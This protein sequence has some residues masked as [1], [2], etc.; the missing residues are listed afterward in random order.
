MN[1][2]GTAI[3]ATAILFSMLASSGTRPGPSTRS[4]SNGAPQR[5]TSSSAKPGHPNCEASDCKTPKQAGEKDYQDSITDLFRQYCEN[6]IG[7]GD[8]DAS[9]KEAGRTGKEDED[10]TEKGVGEK[11]KV[12]CRLQPENF[13]I[14][15]VPDPV[16]THLALYFDRT[17]DTIEEA[18]Q[19]DGYNF[20]QAIVPWDQEAHPQPDDFKLRL[21]A[22]EYQ[23]GKEHFPGVMLFTPSGDL[24]G[25]T[26]VVVDAPK[27]PLAVMLVAESPTAGVNKE[28]FLNAIGQIK[29]L[30]PVT[31]TAKI[32][33]K[34]LGPTFSGSLTSLKNLLSCGKG[35]NGK[36]TNE[37][38]LPCFG[39]ST[40]LSGTISGREAVD[41]FHYRPPNVNATFDT[42][43]ETDAVMLERFIEFIAG[44]SYGDRNYDVRHIAE[45]SEDETAYGSLRRSTTLSEYPPTSGYC[46]PY[47]TEPQNASQPQNRASRSQNAGPPQ[48]AAPSWNSA[49]AC[50]ILRLYFPREI[51]QLR[52]AYQDNS[53]SANGSEHLPFQNLPHNLGVTGA[54]DDTV[55]SFSQKQT[56]LSQEAVLLSIV[57]ELRK[58]AIEFVVLNATDPLDTLFLSHYLRTAYPQGRIVTIG[59]DMLFPREVEDT[60]LHG[61]MALS[62]YSVSPTANHQFYQLWQSGA[63]RMFPTASDIGTYNALHS[64]M[65]SEV[66][67]APA[68]HPCDP[69][70]AEE[71]CTDRLRSLAAERSHAPGVPFCDP[72]VTKN[73]CTDRLRSLLKDKKHNNSEIPLYL[74]QY[75][76][77]ERGNGRFIKYNAP[78]VRL[79]ALGHDGYWPIANLGPFDFGPN[80]KK[81][82]IPTLLPQVVSNP[83]DADAALPVDQFS[84]DPARLEVPD[85]WIAIEVLGLALAAGFCVSLWFASVRSPWQQ[86]AQFAPTMPKVRVWLIA[87]TGLLLILVLL[88]LLWPFF[89]GH[90]DWMMTNAPRHQLILLS[91]VC[92]VFAVTLLDI[93]QRTGLRTQHGRLVWTDL[94]DRPVVLVF[95]AATIL[96]MYFCFF[97]PEHLEENLAGIRHF[98]V[99]RAIQLTSGLSPTLPI[100]FLLAAGLW[101]ANH[102]ASGWI[103]LDERCPRLPS[104][105]VQSR[106]G[107][108][109]EIAQDLLQALRP[110]FSSI[111][112]YLVMLGIAL[113]VLLLS[114]ISLS[115]IR[116]I[117][118]SRFDQ[119]QLVP[120]LVIAS[121]GLIGTTLR[122]WTIWFRARQLLLAL[123]SSPLRRGFQRLEG[124]TWKP[125]WKFGGAGALD[126]YRR[127]LARQR[128]A[129][130]SATNVLTDEL[131]QSTKQNIDLALERTYSAY[132]AA[133]AYEH[134]FSLWDWKAHKNPFSR[135][136]WAA[137]REAEQNLIKQFGCFQQGVG[138]AAREALVYLAGRWKDEKPEPKRRAGKETPADPQAQ[139]EEV[140]TQASERFVSL[141]YVSFLLVV[142]AR[143]RTLIVAISG[144]YILILLA[145]TLYP[146]EPRPSIQIYLVATLVFIVTVVGLVFAQIHRDA[147]LSHITDT[148]P[149]ELGGDFYLRMASFVA[150]PLFTFF[151]SQFPDIGRFFYSW[152]QPALQ[153]LNR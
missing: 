107:E 128:E 15:I 125:I 52:A 57:A 108:D 145:L 96:L 3:L 22:K 45:L 40:I 100:L 153:A 50:S 75:G 81:G 126:E 148:K 19:D 147:T 111:T 2:N 47:P 85:S 150:L 146:F 48:S 7:K 24:F 17:I 117:E 60:T 46:K 122:L 44:K 123:D 103:L 5:S 16:H 14:A 105:N 138:L 82:T 84:S 83:P 134:P 130:Q 56:P 137:R 142:L 114:D 37:K 55:A 136:N 67:V 127:L 18:L 109:D 23:E 151:A 6:G 133:K 38:D 91:G 59:A 104:G 34:I 33:L 39:S 92:V 144:M 31:E 115:P 61:I 1:R 112:H 35:T 41:D 132:E 62:T 43:Q 53:G 99:L 49:Q 118:P 29:Q 36:D 149:G 119:F 76:W 20:Y 79:S 8:N 86:L 95:T 121:A 26:S 135:R 98:Q 124:F 129:L 13:V 113:A 74:I 63:E 110:G 102:T 106:I 139:M 131:T 120:F 97:R 94:R 116:T 42:F 78:P 141:V 80:E 143:M 25:P 87:A 89:H 71:D 93:S 64:L 65:T 32:K 30:T 4:G 73:D 101:W 70:V 72:T 12:K 66:S 88:I 140:K 51:S 21:D 27:D 10:A 54:D 11:R 69:S 58:H 9:E 68:P 77:R 152:L 28:Q 90:L